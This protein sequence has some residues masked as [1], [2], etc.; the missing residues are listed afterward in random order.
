MFFGSYRT[1]GNFDQLAA[2][3][4]QMLDELHE[5]HFFQY[6]EPHTWRPKVNIYET[7]ESFCICVELAGTPREQ[8]EVR[9]EGDSLWI[10]GSRP[11]PDAPK[12]GDEEC[13]PS[14]VRV[15]LMEIDSGSFSR[16]I[17][18]PGGIDVS[19]ISAIYRNGYLW[20]TLPKA[21]DKRGSRS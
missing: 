19:Q 7:A 15:H 13:S 8:I 1:A 4:R 18:L 12:S 9:T 5:G 17:P 11:K 3:F 14:R 2:H 10:H 20:V 6:A 16:R 21:T